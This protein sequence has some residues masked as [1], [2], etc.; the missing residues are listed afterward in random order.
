M[1]K[2]MIMYN[3]TIERV[4]ENDANFFNIIQ[5]HRHH[6]SIPKQ[7]I[8][9][10][11]YAL[12][13]EKSQPSGCAD[14]STIQTSLYVYTNKEDNVRRKTLKTLILIYRNFKMIYFGTKNFFRNF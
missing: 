2:A 1:S 3:R 13:P 6:T 12:F 9:C 7:G 8:Y 14:N 10:Y 5:P 4:A 11:S